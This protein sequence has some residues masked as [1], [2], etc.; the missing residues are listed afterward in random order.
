MRHARLLRV[1]GPSHRR[2]CAT[3]GRE[4]G[5]GMRTQPQTSAGPR[6][7]TLVRP[8]LVV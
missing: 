6:R 2:V 8:Y 5:E 7:M 1:R 4:S 3:Y